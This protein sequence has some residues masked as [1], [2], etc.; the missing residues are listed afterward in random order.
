VSLEP[1][2]VWIQNKMLNA[3]VYVVRNWKSTV[4]RWMPLFPKATF[5]VVMGPCF[6]SVG[7]I[8]TS[9]RSLPS[10]FYPHSIPFVEPNFFFIMLYV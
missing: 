1:C 2:S 9:L 10:L 8:Y 6:L 5:V 7:C 4:L 3:Y